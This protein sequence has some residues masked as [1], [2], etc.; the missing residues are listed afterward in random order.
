M[1]RRSEVQKQVLSLYRLLL[2]EAKSKPGMTDFV[3]NEFRKNKNIPRSN[4]MQVEYL[5]RR[6]TKRL[7]E[8]QSGSMVSMGVFVKDDKSNH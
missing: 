8:I 7:K 4:I 2:R 5:I 3:R 6:G 1:A